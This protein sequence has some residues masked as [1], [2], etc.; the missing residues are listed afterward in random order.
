MAVGPITGRDSRFHRWQA[1]MSSRAQR[2]R[3]RQFLVQGVRPLNCARAYGWTFST[4]IYNADIPLS[5]WARDTLAAVDCEHVAMSAELIEE[6]GEKT[7]PVPELLAV[8]TMPEERLDRID[9]R[10]DFLGVVFDRPVSPGNTGT[11]IRS[12][13]A[14]GAHVVITTGH[15]ADPYDPQA[16]RGSAGSVFA[17]PI[18]RVESVDA[19]IDHFRSV[20]I[21]GTDEHAETD[22]AAVDFQRPSLIVIGNETAGLSRHW[23]ER[24]HTMARIPIGAASSLDAATAGSIALYEATGQ[25]ARVTP[26]PGR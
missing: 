7:E 4:L 15:A 1:M 19:V 12:A 26:R 5:N 14:F 13:D 6:L 18:V 16:I 25:R 2:Q 10:S 20:H 17:V 22:L 3:L 21:V 23:R 9:I 24:V 11:L 8:V